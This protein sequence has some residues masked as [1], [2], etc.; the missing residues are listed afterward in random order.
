MLGSSM[1]MSSPNPLIATNDGT[2]TTVLSPVGDYTR[3]GDAGTTAHSLDSEDDLMVTGE[4][5]VKGVSFFDSNV[6]IG[7]GANTFSTRGLTINQGAADD[8]IISLKSSDVGHA[9]TGA[10]EADT[11]AY[12]QKLAG[13]SGGLTITGI[14]EVN[15]ALVLYGFVTTA[16]TTKATNA[17]APIKI[18]AYETDGGTGIQALAGLDSNILVIQNAATTRFIFDIEGSAH[19]DVEWVAFD[20]YDDIALI[21]DVESYLLSLESEKGTYHRHMLEDI[22][23]I[24]KDSW[25]VENAKPRAMVNMTKLSML[26]H[27]ALLQVG[28]R[29]TRLEDNNKLLREQIV[30]TG[31]LPAV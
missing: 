21:Q 27:G 16:V 20:K 22:G 31:L 5:E 24:G 25:H 11:Y 7:D 3:F 8:A 14:S 10:A 4:L 9:M 17:L 1:Q 18:S 28:E 23:I 12:L 26:H 29:L 19:A 2:K 30:A 13:A 6:F 15:Q